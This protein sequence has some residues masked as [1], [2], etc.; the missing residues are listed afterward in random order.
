MIIGISGEIGCGKTTVCKYLKNEHQ[1]IEYNFANPLK[2]IGT[3][4]GFSDKELYGTQQD[5]LLINPLWGV[6]GREFMQK[7]GTEVVRD[8]LPTIL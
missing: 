4:L 1:F 3:I 7:F 2:Q 5:K 6:S 8:T